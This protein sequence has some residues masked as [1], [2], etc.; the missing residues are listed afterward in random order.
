MKK[1]LLILLSLNLLF[2]FSLPTYATAEEASPGSTTITAQTQTIN[3]PD[4][5]ITLPSSIAAPSAID[6]TTDHVYHDI[7]FSV[8]IEDVEYLGDKEVQVCVAP[9]TGEFLLYCGE[10]SIPYQLYRKA[11]SANETDPLLQAGDLFVAFN[12]DSTFKEQDGFVRIDS[13]DIRKSGSYGAILTFTIRT[14]DRT[15]AEE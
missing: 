12:K 3:Q 4:F 5:T 10:D 2:A 7:A 14:V 1:L 9:K 8:A 15:N 11:N 13:Y 6:R